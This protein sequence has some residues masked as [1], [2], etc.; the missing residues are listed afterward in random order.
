[1]KDILTTEAWKHREVLLKIDVSLCSAGYEIVIPSAATG[2]AV[3][4][5]CSQPAQNQSGS[6]P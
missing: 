1:V 4:R 6:E 2:S 3:E 5:Q